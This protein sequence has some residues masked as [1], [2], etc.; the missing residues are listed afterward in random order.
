MVI[1]QL[2]PLPIVGI[3]TLPFNS[4]LKNL[5]QTLARSRIERALQR[6]RVPGVHLCHDHW[7]LSLELLIKES[8]CIGHK[9]AHS[10]QSTNDNGGEQLQ[11]P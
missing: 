5:S 8:G 1:L 3:Y 11:A 6:C 7:F 10:S 4:F 2:L 9:K